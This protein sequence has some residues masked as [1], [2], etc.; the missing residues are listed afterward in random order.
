[1]QMAPD[2]PRVWAVVPDL[3]LTVGWSWAG[4]GKSPGPQLPSPQVKELVIVESASALQMTSR[5]ELTQRKAVSV[6]PLWLS[7]SGDRSCRQDPPSTFI[8]LPST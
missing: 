2:F 6:A 3:P 1:M 7:Q 4:W 5:R 8:P